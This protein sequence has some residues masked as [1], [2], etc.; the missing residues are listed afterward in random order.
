MYKCIKYRLL[1]SRATKEP[2]D[3][4]SHLDLVGL[5]VLLDRLKRLHPG[6][7]AG[8]VSQHGSGVRGD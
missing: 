3:M 7:T 5:A 2:A 8:V 4:R 1:P 6:R